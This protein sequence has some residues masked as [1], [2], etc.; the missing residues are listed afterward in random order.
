MHA[1]RGLFGGHVGRRA[2]DLAAG[3]QL[4]VGAFAFG[5]TK[6]G[7]LGLTGFQIGIR[8]RIGQ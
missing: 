3:R 8:R 6:V 5:E 7:N 4:A 1:A 2:E